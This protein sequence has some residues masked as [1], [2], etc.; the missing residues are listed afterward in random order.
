MINTPEY[1]LAKLLESIIKL[2]VPNSYKVQST[3]DFLT[4]LKNFGF[5]S[6]QFLI[7][8]DVKSLFINIPLS[9]TINI[10]TDYMHF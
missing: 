3:D 8:Y 2:Y 1:K 9:Y 7:S 6:H 4:K 5:D 10:F